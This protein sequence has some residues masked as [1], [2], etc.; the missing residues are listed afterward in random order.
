MT[1]TYYVATCLN[2]ILIEAD[3]EDQARE[4]GAGAGV[5][6]DYIH[7]V[8]L[9]T[10]AECKLPTWVCRPIVEPPQWAVAL[11]NEVERYLD[12]PGCNGNAKR[13][14]FLRLRNAAAVA[15]ESR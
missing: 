8:R 4:L 11:L 5:G 15:R 1:P 10:D 12:K 7:T 2:Y 3:N 14:A 13:L 6:E 9:A